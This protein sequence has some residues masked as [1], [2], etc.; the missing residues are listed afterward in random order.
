MSQLIGWDPLCFSAY[1]KFAKD[2]ND[3]KYR[4][5][6]T[7]TLIMILFIYTCIRVYISLKYKQP[8]VKDIARIS[9]VLSVGL[10]AIEFGTSGISINLFAKENDCANE[11]LTSA[12]INIVCFCLLST[13][14]IGLFIHRSGKILKHKHSIYDY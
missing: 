7:F 14:F 5:W 8:L 6:V 10:L 13:L 4:T 2:H 3:S 1:Q 11:V 9:L 12:N